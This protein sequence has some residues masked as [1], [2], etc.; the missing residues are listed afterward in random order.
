MASEELIFTLMQLGADTSIKNG[1]GDTPRRAAANDHIRQMVDNANEK[2]KYETYVSQGS[3]TKEIK[4]LQA[5]EKEQKKTRAK[6]YGTI[7]SVTNDGVRSHADDFRD[8]IDKEND[9]AAAASTSSTSSASAKAFA[10]SQSWAPE[11]STGGASARRKG[12][13]GASSRKSKGRGLS[14]RGGR[15]GGLASQQFTAV[16]DDS[17]LLH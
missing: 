12:Q 8:R 2:P 5:V 15:G 1:A 9:H 4:V 13:R 10:T 11:S 3:N 7:S 17:S 14:S 6:S 16:P